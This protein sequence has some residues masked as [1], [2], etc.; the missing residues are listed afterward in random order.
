MLGSD[1]HTKEGKF[2]ISKSK[3]KPITSGQAWAKI[4][5]KVSLLLPHTVCRFGVI[6][7]TDTERG[8]WKDGW[9]YRK[10]DGQRDIE[11]DRHT[12]R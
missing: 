11:M 5:Q 4:R 8:Q 10:T 3:S 9:T 6:L 12:D 7:E 2:K 1:T